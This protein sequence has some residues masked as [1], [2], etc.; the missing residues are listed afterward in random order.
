[1]LQTAGSI[2]L[3][4]LKKVI[5]LKTIVRLQ[6]YGNYSWMYLANQPRPV[7]LAQTLKWFEEQL[8]DFVRVH[9]SE[10]INPT[11]IQTVFHHDAQ[12]MEVGLPDEYKAK[13]SRRRIIEVLA[14]IN[15]SSPAL[16]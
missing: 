7:L 16:A 13:V 6:G 3:P 15:R 9:K 11:F 1:M 5:S 4:G 8:P 12:S 2:K 10:L 14:K